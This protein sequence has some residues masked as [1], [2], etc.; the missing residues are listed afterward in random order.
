MKYYV[1]HGSDSNQCFVNAMAM[2]LMASLKSISLE[3]VIINNINS[4]SMQ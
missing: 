4:C 2:D 1:R 3:M